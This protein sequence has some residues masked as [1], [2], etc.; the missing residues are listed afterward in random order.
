MVPVAGTTASGAAGVRGSPGGD[1]IG[2]FRRVQHRKARGGRS[3]S[4]PCIAAPRRKSR[5]RGG[6]V[7]ALERRLPVRSFL[8]P[9]GRHGRVYGEAPSSGDDIPALR[10]AL[11]QVA[12]LQLRLAVLSR[13]DKEHSPKDEQQLWGQVAERNDPAQASKHTRGRRG[14]DDNSPRDKDEEAT[15]RRQRRRMSRAT[16]SALGCSAVHA[17]E[18]GPREANANFH[19]GDSSISSPLALSSQ[20]ASPFVLHLCVGESGGAT[21]INNRGPRLVQLSRLASPT[22]FH[23]CPVWHVPQNPPILPRKPPMS[24]GLNKEDGK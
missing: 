8:H 14:G 4:G 23:R 15:A 17:G 5:G 18:W 2:F 11:H 3:S 7:V 22:A 12:G 24:S 1:A 20:A 9:G 19:F 13:G 21:R 10:D 16:R 6:G